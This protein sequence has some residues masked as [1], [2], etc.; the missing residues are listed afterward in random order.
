[1]TDKNTVCLWYDTDA[2]EAATFYA[3]IFPDS[4]VHAVHRAPSDFPSGKEGD[5]L[6][7]GDIKLVLHHA[8][9]PRYLIQAGSPVANPLPGDENRHF[10]MKG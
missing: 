7:V 1:M 9:A 4:A 8:V 10:T 6:T 5:V 2:L 3:G